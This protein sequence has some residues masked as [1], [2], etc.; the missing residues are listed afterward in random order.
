MLL[1]LAI[2]NAAFCISCPPAPRHPLRVA[3]PPA[4][5]GRVPRRDDVRTSVEAAVGVSNE[6]HTQA[7]IDFRD[8][9][10]NAWSGEGIAH[11]LLLVRSRVE[12]VLVAGPVRA[13]SKPHALPSMPGLDAVAVYD[14][15]GEPFVA[16]GESKEKAARDVV[17]MATQ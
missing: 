11:A 4:D 16:I 13:I 15:D 17:S 9:V 7:E 6:F 2:L 3:D 5:L 8:R 10:R 1:A 14:V 12:N